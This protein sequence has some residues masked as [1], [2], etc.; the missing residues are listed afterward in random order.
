MKR[1]LALLPLAVLALLA[2]LFVGWTLKRDPDVKPDALVGKPLPA[3]AVRPLTGG[4]EQPL[5]ASVKGPTVVNV[6]ASWCA[7]CRGEHPQLVRLKGEGVR[8]VGLAYKDAPQK[9]SE[10][11]TELGDPFAEVV[12]DLN[13]RG[14][15][16][17][18]ISG[19]PETYVVAADG[20]V[21]YKH[22]GPLGPPDADRVLAE[23]RKAGGA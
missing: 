1:W 5:T 12:S 11:L 13:G 9:T 21:V 7:P 8:I 20:R 23:W 3:V 17:L 6:F 15:I 22:S 2:V 10:F 14:G 16:E 4:A 18:G 19:V